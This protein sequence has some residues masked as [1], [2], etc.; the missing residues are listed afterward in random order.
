MT[1][2]T[3]I[4]SGIVGRLEKMMLSMATASM[5]AVASKTMVLIGRYRLIL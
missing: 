2:P 3:Q 5:T 1:S 4:L